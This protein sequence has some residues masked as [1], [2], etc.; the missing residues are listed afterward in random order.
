[1]S[2][3]AYSNSSTLFLSLAIY[4]P[5]VLFYLLL[6]SFLFDIVNFALLVFHLLFVFVFFFLYSTFLSFIDL[7]LFYMCMY[8]CAHACVCSF[9]DQRSTPGIFLYYSPSYFLFLY[10]FYFT[11]MGIWPTCLSW[12]WKPDEG[13]ASTETGVIGVFEPLYRR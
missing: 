13:I 6:W 2:L 5:L 10:L 8:T 12:P 11:C 1:M 3:S 9:E 7:F 4:S